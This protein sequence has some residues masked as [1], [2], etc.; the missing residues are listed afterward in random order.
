MLHEARA[1]IR[2]V[3]KG[4]LVPEKMATGSDGHFMLL[5]GSVD[6]SPY[7]RMPDTGTETGS[8]NPGVCAHE[9]PQNGF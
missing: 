4:E 7:C 2:G 5:R 3:E 6:V 1:M 9:K 8:L